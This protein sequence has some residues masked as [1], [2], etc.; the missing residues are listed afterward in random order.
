MLHRFKRTDNDEE[1]VLE[2][3]FAEW[4]D[5]IWSDGWSSRWCITLDDGVKAYDY[6]TVRKKFFHTPGNWPMA[7]SAIGVHPDEVPNRMEF[8]KAK[9]GQCERLQNQSNSEQI[10]MY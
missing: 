8:D 6:G 4:T 5:R 9:V 3:T 7:S 2:M 1:V 10:T